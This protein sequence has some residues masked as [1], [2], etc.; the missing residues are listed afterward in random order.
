ATGATMLNTTVPH[1]S[2][3]VLCQRARAVLASRS[4]WAKSMIVSPLIAT[5][6][7]Y[8]DPLTDSVSRIAAWLK[9]PG[10]A[11]KN[12]PMIVSGRWGGW[13]DFVSFHR[14]LD[15]ALPSRGACAKRVRLGALSRRVR[16]AASAIPLDASRR[17][18]IITFPQKSG[19]SSRKQGAA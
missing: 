7:A 1:F 6:R 15:Q 4:S 9:K 19:F 5:V 2:L 10:N 12:L 3:R 11:G 13:K 18:A 17:L 16:C 8:D 14:A